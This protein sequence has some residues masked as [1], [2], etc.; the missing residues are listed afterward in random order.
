MN[1][2]QHQLQDWA[3]QRAVPYVLR[4]EGLSPRTVSIVLV[5]SAATGLCREDS[6]VDLA[7]L[8]RPRLYQ[9]LSQGKPWEKGRPTEVILEGRQLHY[10]AASVA[11]VQ[12]SLEA[13]DDKAH[14]MYGTALP[15]LDRPSLY[16]DGIAPLAG[17]AEFRRARLEGKL[18]ELLRRLVALRAAAL[19]NEPLI[20][21]QVSLEVISLAI[22]TVA[23]IDGVPFDV[24][25]RL[26]ETALSGR[27]GRRVKPT[28][29]AALLCASAWRLGKPNRPFLNHMQH[30]QY[31]LTSA[32]RKA[33]YTVGLPKQDRRAAE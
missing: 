7:I 19:E 25:K 28:I 17:S 30:L 16:V 32:A 22:K 33:G 26:M 24:R 5:G 31:S 14:Y 29:S 8:C 9:R 1:S 3:I 20:L 6:D 4:K 10:F 15:L 23:L 21:S 2:I 13:L 11:A 27:L 18:D 12:R